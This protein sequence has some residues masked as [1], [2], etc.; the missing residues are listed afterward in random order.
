MEGNEVGKKVIL[1]ASF[2]GGP[3]DMK[4]RYLDAMSL[5]QHFGKPTLFITVT[6]NPEWDEITSALLPGQTSQ[7]RPD[8]VTRIFHSKI[9]K[10]SDEIFKVGIFGKSVA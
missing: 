5:V 10:I 7:D 9:K 3:R 2:I 6:C 4:S 1:P 8:I